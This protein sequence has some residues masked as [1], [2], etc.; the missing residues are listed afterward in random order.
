FL[1]ALGRARRIPYELFDPV[2]RNAFRAVLTTAFMHS[3]RRFMRSRYWLLL[4]ALGP[5]TAF[6]WG[7]GCKLRADRAGGVD[8]KGVEK[9]VVRTGAG[10]M[11]VI[12]RGNAVRIEARGV[13]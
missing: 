8:A 12:G 9:V 13:A 1:T 4:L 2:N 7:D 3:G 6:A 11:K 5:V 10:D